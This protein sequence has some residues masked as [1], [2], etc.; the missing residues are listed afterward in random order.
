M[1]LFLNI[2]FIL[3]LVTNLAH[4]ALFKLKNPNYKK[5]IQSYDKKIKQF[6]IGNRT[7]VKGDKNEILKYYNEDELEYVKPV[8]RELFY[9]PND[10]F[11]AQQWYLD[12]EY[13]T[14]INWP[15][16]IDLVNSNDE[17]ILL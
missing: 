9:I 17:L 13:D 2:L 6:S 16:A 8:K 4:S 15:E 7:Y 5:F 12:N 10:E 3:L 11:F 14:D 1:K